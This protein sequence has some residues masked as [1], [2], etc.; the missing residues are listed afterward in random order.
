MPTFVANVR[1]VRPAAVRRRLSSKPRLSFTAADVRRTCEQSQPPF[2][3]VREYFGEATPRATDRPMPVS[4]PPPDRT[5][6]DTD[7]PS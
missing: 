6:V 4:L 5:L 2:Q 1:R 3:Q 7:E